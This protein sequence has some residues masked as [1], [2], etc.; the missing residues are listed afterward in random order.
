MLCVRGQRQGRDKAWATSTYKESWW[1]LGDEE[2]AVCLSGGRV[3]HQGLKAAVPQS[4]VD[5]TEGSG[6]D[7][8]GPFGLNTTTGTSSDK[9]MWRRKSSSI[10]A[11]C[12]Q[13][14]DS[15][16]N[17]GQGKEGHDTV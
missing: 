17:L 16:E 14:P 1:A 13:A 15:W 11:C 6:G 7:N 12:P 5:C 9:Q 10:F 3:Y 2:A 8:Y 4:R